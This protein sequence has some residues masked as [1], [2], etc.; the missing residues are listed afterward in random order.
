MQSIPDLDL[1]RQFRMMVKTAVTNNSVFATRND[2]K[3]R[4][5]T[6]AIPAHHL[7]DKLDRLLPLGE[8]A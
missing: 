8:N 4:R 3:L 1:S 7:V 5:Y 6:V 2:G